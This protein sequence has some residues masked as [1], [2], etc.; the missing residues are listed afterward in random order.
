MR[1]ERQGVRSARRMIEADRSTRP[2]SAGSTVMSDDPLCLHS[3]QLCSAAPCRPFDVA[4]DGISIG[5]AAASALL[6]RL[7][8]TLDG[9]DVPLLGVGESSDA[10]HM[11]APHPEGDGA[12][13]AMQVALS[14]ASLEPASIEYI[15][16]HGTGTPSTI[17]SESQA[18]TSLRSDD[19][20]SSTK[21][22]TGHVPGA[23]VRWKR[24]SAPSCC[25]MADAR[26]CQYRMRGPCAHG[27]LHQRKSPCPDREEDLGISFG[28]GG[29]NCS[30]ISVAPM[31]L[32]A[33]VGGI[34]VLGPGIDDWPH[35]SAVL[36]GLRDYQPAPR[37]C[38]CRRCCR[39]RSGA[40]RAASCAWHC[41]RA[42]GDECRRC[43]PR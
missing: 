28:F 5:E 38:R 30:L 37:R 10:Y 24:S 17:R 39:P 7:P 43:R 11:S 41:G 33:Y 35:A 14:S 25:K 23:Q 26:W 18:V 9:D 20:C 6:E 2:S 8:G 32:H 16:L 3:L 15:N 19:A 12:R 1:V 40:V 4:R 42:G 27:Q 29:T 34:G 21:G 36:C 13:R 22:A 31:T